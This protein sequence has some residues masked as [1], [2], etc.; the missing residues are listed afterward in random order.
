MSRL[1]RACALLFAMTVPSQAGAQEWPAKYVKMIV[2]GSSGSAPDAMA[3]FIADRLTQ[4]W[5]QQVIVEN[6]PG[7]GGNIGVAAAARAAPDEA[8]PLFRVRPRRPRN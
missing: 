3:R 1:M 7:A 5:G 6:Q 2:P 4:K 8:G